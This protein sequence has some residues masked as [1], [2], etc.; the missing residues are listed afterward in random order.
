M[1][2]L[3]PAILTG[4][5]KELEDK[6]SVL[7]GQSQWVHVD[8]MD[9][10]FV[11]NVSFPISALSKFSGEFRFEAH[12]LVEDPEKYVQDCKNAKIPRIIFHWESTK[13]PKSVLGEAKR[14]F[15]EAVMGINPPTSPQVFSSLH[16]DLD[17]AF[18]LSVHPGLQGRDFIPSSL[19]KIRELKELHPLLPI[20]VDGGVNKETIRS[21][22]E[23]GADYVIVGSVLWKSS[24]PV[25][26]LR[27]LEAMVQ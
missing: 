12:L 7:R 27:E 18:V 15:L 2:K 11:P 25:A 10:K 9:G 8:I 22:F 5:V 3:I 4:D 23:A 16:G 26:T 13:D 24:D 1:Q 6:L 21:C 20:G 17:G 19:E 14:C